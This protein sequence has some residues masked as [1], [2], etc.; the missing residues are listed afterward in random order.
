MA[1][2]SSLYI[3]LNYWNNK[4][5]EYNDEIRRLKR[6]R[7][8]I[9][10]IKSKLKSIADG[11]SDDVNGKLRTVS[12]KLSNGLNCPDK[13]SRVQS[14]LAGKSEH[15]I[16]ADDKLT[17]ADNELQRELNDVNRRIGEAESALSRAKNEVNATKS[18]ISAEERRLREE[19]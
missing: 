14:I 11:S 18:A 8:D 10:G 19:A 13:N 7:S 12:E 16:G 17:P 6:R 4:V 3:T 9:E 2:L 5:N 1:S 15:R